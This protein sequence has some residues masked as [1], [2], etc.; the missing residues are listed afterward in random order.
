[1]EEEQLSV[2]CVKVVVQRKGGKE[3]AERGGVHDAE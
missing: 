2:I 3:N 1:M